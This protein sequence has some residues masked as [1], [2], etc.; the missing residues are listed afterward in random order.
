MNFQLFDTSNIASN[1]EV[2]WGTS[3]SESAQ[4]SSVRTPTTGQGKPQVK[5]GGVSTLYLNNAFLSTN[6]TW[7]FKGGVN[8][9]DPNLNQ[10]C[11]Y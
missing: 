1:L 3:A 11:E 7:V 8:M 5:T 4:I 9:I 10:N 6:S 2:D